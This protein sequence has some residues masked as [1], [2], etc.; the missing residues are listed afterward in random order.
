MT[1]FYNNNDLRA[2]ELMEVRINCN[3]FLEAWLENQEW[4]E[5]KKIVGIN[6]DNNEEAVWADINARARGWYEEGISQWARFQEILYIMEEIFD[7][8][9]LEFEY[10]YDEDYISPEMINAVKIIENYY[11]NAKYSPYT[12]IGRKFINKMY[13]DI[14]E[15]TPKTIKIIKT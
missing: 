9:D 6:Y 7:E 5:G 10:D 15:I 4:E 12:Q 8:Y 14:E 13:D 1:N 2:G 3:Y 11:L